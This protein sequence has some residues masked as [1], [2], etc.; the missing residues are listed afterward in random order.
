MAPW[1]CATSSSTPAPTPVAA[2][3]THRIC[4]IPLTI[5]I[6]LATQDGPLVLRYFIEHAEPYPIRGL[7]NVTD[8]W[9]AIWQ[10]YQGLSGHEQGAGTGWTGL[11]EL[12]RVVPG[13]LSPCIPAGTVVRCSYLVAFVYAVLCAGVLTVAVCIPSSGKR[14]RSSCLS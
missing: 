1:Y 9:E 12:Y 8:F 6:V 5:H 11:D 13:K 14:A 7:F 10:Q 4:N 2:A 3:T